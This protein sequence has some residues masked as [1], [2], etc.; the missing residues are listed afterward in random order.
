MSAL[1]RLALVLFLGL[2]NTRLL[3][4]AGAP[5]AASAKLEIDTQFPGGNIIVDRIEGDRV[6]LRPDLRDTQGWWFYWNFRVRNAAGRTFTFQ[7]PDKNPIGVRGPAVSTDG[8]CTWSWLGADRVKGSSFAYTFDKHANE[9]RFAFA[10]PYQET[11]LERFLAAHQ[12]NPHL[13]VRELCRSRG[14]RSVRRIHVGVL[15]GEPKHRIFLT[16]RHHAC[17]SLASY[18]LEGFLAAALGD[19]ELGRWFQE[20][21]EVLAVPMVDKDGVEEGDQGKNRKPYDHNRD[22]G[23]ESIYPSVAAIREL[24]PEW[25][26]GRL[27]VSVDLHCPW[28]RGTHNEVI[29]MVGQ[30]YPEIWQEQTALGKILQEVQRGPLK[31]RVSDNLPF[32]QAWN[33]N[34]NY[35]GRMSCSR[36]AANLEGIRLAT[37]FEFPYANAGGQEVTANNARAFGRDLAQAVREYLT[38]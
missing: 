4:A 7:F 3:T 37:S 9:T 26:R 5:E 21:V 8:G 18:V 36:W 17:E 31:Y 29:Y 13:A 20:N 14:G 33:K 23:G 27:H 1:V 34:T 19:T 30:P 22:Y 15:D 10:V 28:I 11:H 38:Q 16:A 12:D 32:G 24:V 6:I 2:L 35:N 25:S